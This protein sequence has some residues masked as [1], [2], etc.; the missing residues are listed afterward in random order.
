MVFLAKGLNTGS[1]PLPSSSESKAIPSPLAVPTPA[2]TKQP[3]IKPQYNTLDII[4]AALFNGEF[5]TSNQSRWYI[6]TY[7]P[8]K[9]FTK[10]IKTIQTIRRKARMFIKNLIK[11]G[12]SL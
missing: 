4:E 10:D 7:I 5:R 12:K 11:N 2:V 9:N 6:K 3:P 8:K 1:Y